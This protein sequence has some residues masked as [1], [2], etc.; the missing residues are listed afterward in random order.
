MLKMSDE[1]GNPP[2]LLRGVERW[3]KSQIR[4]INN[5]LEKSKLL[6]LA[7]GRGERQVFATSGS[8]SMFVQ[9]ARGRGSI[10]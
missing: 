9:P 6:E 8:L 5:V 10:V 2:A 4:R 1:L 7:R 3:S